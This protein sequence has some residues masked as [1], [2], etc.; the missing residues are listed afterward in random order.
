MVISGWSTVHLKLSANFMHFWW[1]KELSCSLSFSPI[2]FHLRN[3]L[4]TKYPL[5][6]SVQK[7]AQKYKMYHQLAHCTP[8]MDA[9]K[10]MQ[11]GSCD[12]NR[13][14][15]ALGMYSPWMV[16]CDWSVTH[17]FQ[18]LSGNAWYVRSS[19]ISW[20]LGLRIDCAKVQLDNA[21][22]FAAMWHIDIWDSETDGTV[23]EVRGED[24]VW[25][26]LVMS[27]SR[28]KVTSAPIELMSQYHIT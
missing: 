1:Y 27:S 13:Q 21:W 11:V 4:L 3:G 16:L 10:A 20:S 24:I 23:E 12:C 8:S 9:P 2:L 22:C 6:K 25:L 18:S 15:A 17:T 5:D 28:C 26:L 7:I 14:D 19:K